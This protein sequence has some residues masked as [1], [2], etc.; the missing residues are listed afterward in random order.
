MRKSRD[1]NDMFL[2]IM[3]M[4]INSK[5]KINSLFSTASK[6]E[7]RSGLT[8]LGQNSVEK[9]AMTDAT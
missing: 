8:D 4:I 5:L 6:A 1:E 3:I 2:L 7:D 9:S